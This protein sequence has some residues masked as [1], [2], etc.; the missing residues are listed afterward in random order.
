MITWMDLKDV[1]EA[2]PIDLAGYAL[3]SRIDLINQQFALWMLYALQKRKIV[4]PKVK[5]KYWKTTHRYGVWLPNNTEEALRFDR[6]TRTDSWE[7][8][9]NK[10]MKIGLISIL[11]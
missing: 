3:A 8:A 9:V 7:K 11:W 6:E 1:K 4:I 10:D 5:M 2:N